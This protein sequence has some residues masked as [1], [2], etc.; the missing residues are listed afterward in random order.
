MAFRVESRALLTTALLLSASLAWPAE[1]PAKPQASP[2]AGAPAATAKPGAPAKA[3]ASKTG[4]SKAARMAA[5][6]DQ[7]TKKSMRET[8]RAVSDPAVRAKQLDIN[9][10]SKQQLMTLPGVTEA[11]ADQ[12]IAGRPYLT[13]AHVM[14]RKI[15]SDELYGVI[16]NRI[17]V[18]PPKTLAPKAP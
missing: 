13:K 14:T 2:A 5:A 6:K 15:I 1:E 11:I 16:R 12:I 18:E 4:T 17:K 10:A 9:V 7:A 3:G 8:A